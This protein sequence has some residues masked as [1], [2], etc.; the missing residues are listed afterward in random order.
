MAARSS[1]LWDAARKLRVRGKHRLLSR[2]LPARG[3]RLAKVFGCEI[4]LDLANHIDRSIYIGGYELLNTHR[5]ERLLKPGDTVI[6]V[7][8]NIGYF[9]LLSAARVGRGGR[10]F[11][12]EPHPLNFALLEA[13]LRRNALGQVQALR[14]GLGDQVGEG[15]VSMPDQEKY[16]NRTAT[17]LPGSGD[18]PFKVPLST[19]DA[20]IEQWA[21]ERVDLLKIDV[22]G[23]ESKIVAGALKALESGRVR[24]V[25]IELNDYWLAR[26]G[27]SR[28][29]LCARLRALGFEDS[30][31]RWRARSLLLG[32]TEDLHYSW[33]GESARR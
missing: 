20:L 18:P 32:D 6:D 11:A 30:A 3:R 15:E 10:V 23:Y 4:E 28:A 12:I 24:N 8:A 31:E 16:P 5:F 9:T 22:D 2:L 25:I 14:I 27:E 19:L 33:V 21:I 29:T 13:T 7:G 26:S 1:R 17:M